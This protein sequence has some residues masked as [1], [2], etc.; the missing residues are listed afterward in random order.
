M[1]FLLELLITVVLVVGA[2]ARLTRLI[3]ADTIAGPLRA[4]LITWTKS[5]KVG[6]FITCP[7]CIGFWISVAV[8]YAAWEVNGWPLTGQS[9]AAGIG[10]A[11]STSYAVG[12]LAGYDD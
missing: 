3:T 12:I 10:L 6:E 2:S 8:T 4:K 9:L 5:T 1:S 7:W 11:L